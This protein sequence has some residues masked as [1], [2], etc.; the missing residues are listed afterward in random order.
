METAVGFSSLNV[1]LGSA[2]MSSSD[3]ML[4]VTARLTFLLNDSALQAG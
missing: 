2:Q 4:H 3:E 1:I